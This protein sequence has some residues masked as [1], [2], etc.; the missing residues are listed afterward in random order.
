MNWLIPLIRWRRFFL[1][2]L[3]FGLAIL[4]T[5]WVGESAQRVTGY[6]S[7]SQSQSQQEV[8][9]D[10][11]E[12]EAGPVTPDLKKIE[13]ERGD[14]LPVSN[15]EEA[16][17]VLEKIKTAQGLGE[18]SDLI[19]GEGIEDD[20]GSIFYPASQVYKGIPVIGMESSLEVK[21]SETRTFEGSWQPNIE[22]SIETAFPPDEAL[23]VAM[24]ERGVPDSRLIEI[25]S[26][27]KKVI[28]VTGSGPKVCWQMNAH[29]TNPES[30][31][32][33][34]WVDANMPAIYQK[35]PVNLHNDS[36]A[37]TW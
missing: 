23:L 31:V 8:F 7:K 27:A 34:Y 26:V 5:W 11:A 29:L 2:L 28:L 14:G 12:P 3:A 15:R 22:M 33:T 32:F 35:V 19:P 13:W 1:V 10:K 24:R 18:D 9:D 17:G 36:G 25:D 4:F 21:D 6:E 37:S 20:L 30:E 16:E